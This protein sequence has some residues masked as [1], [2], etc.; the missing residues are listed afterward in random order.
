[1]KMKLG[2]VSIALFL[3]TKMELLLANDLLKLCA[4]FHETTHRRMNNI[5]NENSPNFTFVKPLLP[6]CTISVEKINI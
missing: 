4:K 6:D 3:C 1:M 2:Q 5:I